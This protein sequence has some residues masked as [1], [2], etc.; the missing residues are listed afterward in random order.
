MI[1]ESVEY[2]GAVEAVPRSIP[3]DEIPDHRM[4]V[5]WIVDSGCGHDLVS[6]KVL[7]G[8]LDLIF[9]ATKP[10][11]FNTANGLAPSYEM[12]SIGV[13]EL[14]MIVKAW[15]MESSP[16]V[17]SLGKRCLEEG[18]DFVWP[19]KGVPYFI[20]PEGRIIRLL[21]KG[22]IPYL[23]PGHAFCQ[24]MDPSNE[25]PLLSGTC[26]MLGP[27]GSASSNAPDGS[28]H[29]VGGNPP[30]DRGADV[31]VQ[32]DGNLL[33]ADGT[34]SF[35][36][37]MQIVPPPKPHAYERLKRLAKTVPHILIHKPFNPFC[38]VC[39]QAKMRERPHKKGAFTNSGSAEA[40]AKEFGDCV[41]G[42]FLASK[43]EVMRAVGGYHDAL[44][45]R[46]IGTGVKMCYPCTG[47]STEE[48]IKKVQL[49]GGNPSVIKRYYG[50]K[51]GGM[52]KAMTYFGICQRASQPGKPVTNSLSERAN[53]DI[54]Q[55]ARSLLASA[56]LPECFWSFAAP[57]YCIMECLTYREDGHRIYESW[58]DGKEWKAK[59]IPFGALV[60]YKPPETRKKD[61]PGKWGTR[62]QPG[63]FAGYELGERGIWTGMYLVW[64]LKDFAD[65]KF[66]ST[67]Y[68]GNVK[69]GEPNRV[70]TIEH[71]DE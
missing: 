47:R 29:S 16:A 22:N 55:G 37:Q 12:A 46:D 7:E 42:D 70:S 31:E 6:R 10:I 14:A 27:T 8:F 39:Q 24:P 60:D 34:Y 40:N 19:R 18:Y 13:R 30:T 49:F 48:C 35:E 38:E 63:I 21:V 25:F 69:V 52:T 41:T 17:L 62:A 1:W 57:Y 2:A 54:L 56:G 45:L 61:C 33:D 50:D 51:E 67:V 20:S 43:G 66:M 53:Q 59:I 32:G 71:T 26:A 64:N 58:T 9:R 4:V 65:M 23:H 11:T 68:A 28:R 44:N 3:L 36:A 5:K 15:V